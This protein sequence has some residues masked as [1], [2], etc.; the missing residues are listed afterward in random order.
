[1]G[2]LVPAIRLLQW[3]PTVLVDLTTL[4][5]LLVQ[6]RLWRPLIL[7]QWLLC[8]LVYLVDQQAHLYQ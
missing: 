6:L 8:F 7:I 1:M 3:N 5:G 2:L 4:L